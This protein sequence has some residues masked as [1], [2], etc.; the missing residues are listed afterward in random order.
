M[1]VALVVSVVAEVTS[2]GKSVICD[3][4][5]AIATLFAEVILPLASTVN[6]D[7]CV[8]EPAD[9]A[10][11]LSGSLASANVPLVICVVLKLAAAA[12]AA[13]ILPCASIVTTDISVAL[14]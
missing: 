14:P 13:V 12:E 8:A 4:G 1:L 5:I 2:V 6:L 9:V 7:T 11:T 3:F 10:V